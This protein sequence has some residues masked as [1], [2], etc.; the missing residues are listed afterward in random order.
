LLVTSTS[1]PSR[2]VAVVLSCVAAV[3]ATQFFGHVSWRDAPMVGEFVPHGPTPSSRGIANDIIAASSSTT[4]GKAVGQVYF[5]MGK[6]R[7]PSGLLPA[8]WFQAITL[9]LT[10]DTAARLAPLEAG[11]RDRDDAAMVARQLLA[12]KRDLS[13]VVAPR[14]LQSLRHILPRGLRP[15]VTTWVVAS[16]ERPHEVTR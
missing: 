4:R 3:A 11:F 6:Q 7:G 10:T 16:R 1:S 9:T 13:V 14:H 5:V 15:Q 8:F 2:G 12:S